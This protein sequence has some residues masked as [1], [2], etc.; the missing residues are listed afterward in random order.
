MGLITVTFNSQTSTPFPVWI[1][2]LACGLFTWKEAGCGPGVS[3][4]PGSAFN[5]VVTSAK[6]GSS[7][8]V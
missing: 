6:P 4:D 2:R 3:C 8:I 1:A 7:G 5:T